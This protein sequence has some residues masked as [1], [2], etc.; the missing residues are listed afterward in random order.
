MEKFK[1]KKDLLNTLKEKG[2][3]FMFDNETSSIYW[4]YVGKVAVV[5][6]DEKTIE[7]VD[8]WTW[9][10]NFT[11]INI[12]ENEINN[13]HSL[14]FAFEGHA[15]YIFNLIKNEYE[16]NRGQPECTV[17]LMNE[18]VILEDYSLTRKQ[19]DKIISK[20]PTYEILAKIDASPN[21][22]AERNIDNE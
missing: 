16:E 3:E 12:D 22:D 9:G 20:L 6:I 7:Y 10:L 21:S 14:V 11:S 2:Y 8:K 19:V 13:V 4:N 17:D 5:D 1:T 18:E 15:K